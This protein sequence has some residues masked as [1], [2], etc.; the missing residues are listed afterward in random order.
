MSAIHP[1]QEFRDELICPICLGS[2]KDPVILDCGHNF[3]QACIT[4][5]CEAGT[6]VCPQCRKS[7]LKGELR[8]NRQLEEVVNIARGLDRECEKHGESFSLFCKEDRTLLCKVCRVSRERKVHT[9]I[10]IE[11][12]AEEVKVGHLQIPKHV[13]YLVLLKVEWWERTTRGVLFDKDFWGGG[14]VEGLRIN[15]TGVL[16]AP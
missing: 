11:A 9:V 8:P 15:R 4:D 2:F 5:C 7:F 16:V 3:C 10:P 1:V 6:G 13:S 14:F 12:A